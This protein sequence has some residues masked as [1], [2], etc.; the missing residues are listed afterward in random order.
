MLCE[1]KG[2]EYLIQQKVQTIED[3]IDKLNFTKTKNTCSLKNTKT[4]RVLEQ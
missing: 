4:F 3:E 2:Q 1:H